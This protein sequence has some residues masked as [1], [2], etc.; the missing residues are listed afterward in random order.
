MA[1]KTDEELK[2]DEMFTEYLCKLRESLNLN[3]TQM[4]NQ[5]GMT[6]QVYSNL[7]SETRTPSLF[8]V[9][10]VLENL[11]M[12]PGDFFNELFDAFKYE[13]QQVQVLADQNKAKEYYKSTRKKK[14][15]SED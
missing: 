7:E 4:A 2:F 3:K 6:R 10:R 15:Q 8:S 1:E 12:R 13:K 11:D 9:F 5:A 14:A